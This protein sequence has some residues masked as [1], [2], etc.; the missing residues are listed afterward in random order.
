MSPTDI[1]LAGLAGLAVV[2]VTRL[3]D[4]LLPKDRHLRWIDDIT[5]PNPDDAPQPDGEPAPDREKANDGDG[6]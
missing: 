5:V 2:A 3:I 1:L 4:L 6:E